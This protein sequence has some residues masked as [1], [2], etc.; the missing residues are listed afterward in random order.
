MPAP[1]ALELASDRL[2][3][4]VFTDVGALLIG[5]VLSSSLAGVT[6]YQAVAYLTLFPN[7]GLDPKLWV[8]FIWLFDFL[9][10]V[11]NSAMVYIYFVNH[12]DDPFFIAFTIW[13]WDAGTIAMGLSILFV[14]LFFIVR[15]WRLRQ[16]VYP[17]SRRLNLAICITFSALAVY[18][19]ASGLILAIWD[20]SHTVEPESRITPLFNS[21]IGTETALDILI[22]AMLIHILHQ[23]R[24]E[25]APRKSPFAQLMVFFLT[26]GCVIAIYQI[27]LLVVPHLVGASYAWVPLLFCLSRVYANSA[28]MTL[29]N[30]RR[31]NADALSIDARSSF[32]ITLPTFHLTSDELPPDTP[33]L[34]SQTNSSAGVH[35]QDAG[36]GSNSGGS[37]SLAK[38]PEGIFIDMDAERDGARAFLS[39]PT[40]LGKGRQ[41]AL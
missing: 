15:L 14:Q 3:P 6:A 37:S 31:P 41:V 4:G 33:G 23:H 1:S 30:R 35:T 26:R 34:H 38:P 17:Q 13:A 19:E 22:T 32:H 16:I 29:N 39:S 28:I 11:F 2:P 12:Q 40:P 24:N 5:A 21:N 25:F 10:A 20:L 7:D 18:T 8:I 36:S 9:S 27:I